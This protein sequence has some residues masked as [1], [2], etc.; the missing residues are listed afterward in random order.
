MEIMTLLIALSLLL[1]VI[2]IAGIV[3]CFKRHDLLMQHVFK[4]F[5]EILPILSSFQDINETDGETMV[6]TMEAVNVIQDT[7]R[8]L[9]EHYIEHHRTL[10]Q[11]EPMALK[12]KYFN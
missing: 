9:M 4:A 7:L 3:V 10:H 12:T 1:N 5:N 11:T 6:S 2:C 8:E